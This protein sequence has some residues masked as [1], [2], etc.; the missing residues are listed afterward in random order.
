MQAMTCFEDLPADE[1][2]RQ[3]EALRRKMM[4]PGRFCRVI[5][6]NSF[7]LAIHH[8][9][10][11]Y[12]FNR[13][14]LACIFMCMSLALATQGLKP[15]LLQ[16]FNAAHT[17]DQIRFSQSVHAWPNH[18]QHRGGVRVCRHEC[19]W[20]SKQLGS[21]AVGWNPKKIQ[22]GCRQSFHWPG[23]RTANRHEPPTGSPWWIPRL[24]TLLDLQRRGWV[25][26]QQQ[27]IWTTVPLHDPTS[28]PTKQQISPWPTTLPLLQLGLEGRDRQCPPRERVL[29][30]RPAER[31]K[32]RDQERPPGRPTRRDT[33]IP[34][35]VVIHGPIWHVSNDNRVTK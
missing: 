34:C 6:P 13:S 2:K 27:N 1:R 18:E 11:Q 29:D 10:I 26:W 33:H 16:K 35:V 28:L 21:V 14:L 30:H 25:A 3:R 22:H 20:R 31:E 5:F 7:W 12:F 4:G 8:V 9:Q 24:E 32:E 23:D 19:V 17:P 15:G